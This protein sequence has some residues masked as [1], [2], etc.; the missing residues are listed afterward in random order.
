[1]IM[2]LM[3]KK[4][5]YQPF[6]KLSKNLKVLELSKLSNLEVTEQK[7]GSEDQ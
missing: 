2:L 7:L 4:V 6:N 5:Y 3:M 1:M